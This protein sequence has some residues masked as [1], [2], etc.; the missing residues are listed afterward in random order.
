VIADFETRLSIVLGELLPT[1]FRGRVRVTPGDGS[2]TEPR[3]LVG[4]REARALQAGLG[5]TRRALVPGAPDPRRV[6]RAECDVVITCTGAGSSASEARAGLEAAAYALD[7]PDLRNGSALTEPGDQ[8]FVIEEMQLQSVLAPL[9]ASVTD[10]PFCARLAAR[11]LFWPRAIEGVAGVE[12][13]SVRVRGVT[14]PLSITPPQP[15]LVAGGDP[16]DLAVYVELPVGASLPFGSLAIDVLG[17]G[18]Q[19]ARGTLAG[20]TEG[21]DG[22]RLV[23]LADNLALVTYTPPTAPAVDWLVVSLDNGNGGAGIELG[24]FRLP[25]RAP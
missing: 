14:L 4:V 8:G 16:V 24:R 15:R 5:D 2:T 3:V 10:S 22:V 20:G 1:P 21:Q 12:I 17:P 13:A 6:L 25:T 23:E 11:G 19:P 18:A 7:A 9:D